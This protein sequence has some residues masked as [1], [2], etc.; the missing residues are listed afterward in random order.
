MDE[1]TALATLIET[2]DLFTDEQKVRILDRLAHLASAE[3]RQMGVF[4]SQYL[5]QEIVDLQ[6]A[7]DR[8]TALLGIDT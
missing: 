5:Q 3:V 2:S 1:R 4:L 6:E 7:Q 8:I